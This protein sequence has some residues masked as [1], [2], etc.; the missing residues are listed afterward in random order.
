MHT[1]LKGLL[2]T[3]FS[4]FIVFL[5]SGCVSKI[6]IK[7]LEPSKI[8]PQKVNVVAISNIRNDNLNQTQS[9]ANTISN[10]II[11]NKRVFTLQ[12]N[13]VG[14]DAIIEGE[15]INSSANYDVY[16]EEEI[17]YSRCRYFRYDERTST[18]QCLQYDIRY[19]PCEAKYYNVTTALNLVN[20]NT[21]AIIFSKTYDK[22][23]KDNICYDRYFSYSPIFPSHL[24]AQNDSFRVNSQIAFEIARDFVNDISPNY[25]YIN[26][27]I[28]N[29]LYVN[30]LY[31]T[32]HKDRFKTAVSYLEKNEFNIAFDILEVLDKELNG[33]SYEVAY[34]LGL[35]FE[36]QDNLE[37]SNKLYLAARDLVIDL[38]HRNLIDYAISR[39]NLNLKNKIK[40]KS[41]LN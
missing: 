4:I 17:D 32:S 25:I 10:K 7:A 2:L 1:N 5:F 26:V 34:N 22:S 33:K 31:T 11:D 6:T 15:I 18:K 3:I 24:N 30:K 14:V 8:S 12:N 16:Y 29:E 28:I 35:I 23:S 41:Q 38:K 36:A 27:E 40:A 37:M 19:I 9:I 13:P 20:P 21:S 39:T